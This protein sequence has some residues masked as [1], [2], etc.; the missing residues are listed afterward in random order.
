MSG[1]FNQLSNFFSPSPSSPVAPAAKADESF[2][3][4]TSPV[5]A[6]TDFSKLHETPAT[7]TPAISDPVYSTDPKEIKDAVASFDFTNGEQFEQLAQQVVGQ[8]GDI[9]ALKQL[10]NM[11]TQA[12]VAQATHASTRLSEHAA[13]QVA[14][15]LQS[16]LPTTIKDVQSSQLLNN[17]YGDAMS[18]AAFSPIVQDIKARILRANPEATPEQITNLTEDYLTQFATVLGMNQGP[19]TVNGFPVQ[20]SASKPQLNY[21][22]IFPPVH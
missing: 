10:L 8:G 22:D 3:Q 15:R 9:N 1:L 20:Q 7:T 12:G 14:Q 17:K 16:Q 5:A 21:F 13:Q 18:S 2:Q 4:S 11:V 19:K 6:T